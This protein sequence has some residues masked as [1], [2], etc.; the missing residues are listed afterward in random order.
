MD[1]AL[2]LSR[3]ITELEEDQIIELYCGSRTGVEIRWWLPRPGESDD[4]PLD[5]EGKPQPILLPDAN[6]RQKLRAES[7]GGPVIDNEPRYQ[8][9]YEAQYGYPV[10]DELF[11]Q[12]ENPNDSVIVI[13]PELG[14]LTVPRN[15]L[16]VV[17]ADIQRKLARKQYVVEDPEELPEDTSNTRF[18]PPSGDA[19]KSFSQ[20][21]AE[22]NNDGQ[23]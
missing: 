13:D 18:G 6:T 22:A 7:K 1:Y 17:Q 15:M 2:Q 14:R 12:P 10:S 5:D 16:A 21:Q 23:D 20:R 11:K 4:L 8:D 3:K 9:Y 19:I